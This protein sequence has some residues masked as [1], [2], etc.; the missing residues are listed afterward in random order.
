MTDACRLMF[1]LLHGVR[2]LVY[3][4]VAIVVSVSPGLQRAVDDEAGVK[5]AQPEILTCWQEP[6]ESSRMD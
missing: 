3:P 5:I 6:R 4:E 1:R 2:E